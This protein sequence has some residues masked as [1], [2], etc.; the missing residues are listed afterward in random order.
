MIVSSKTA[1]VVSLAVLSVVLVGGE[2][3]VPS[4]TNVAV[5]LLQLHHTGTVATVAGR[6]IRRSRITGPRCVGVG[7]LS[8]QMV[9]GTET[10]APP[11]KHSLEA[12]P[13]S[14]VHPAVDDGIIHGVRH[15]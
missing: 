4:L 3:V 9:A 8:D 6:M 12:F 10:T 14:F 2:T 13:E 7:L 5:E 1:V 11:E 15:G